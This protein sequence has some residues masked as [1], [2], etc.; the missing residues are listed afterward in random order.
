[1]AHIVTFWLCK[2]TPHSGFVPA[3]IYPAGG[4]GRN[5]SVNYHKNVSR[6]AAQSRRVGT[7]RG[8]A[9]MSKYSTAQDRSVSSVS[10]LLGRGKQ[11]GLGG[12]L[13]LGFMQEELVVLQRGKKM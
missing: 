11:P 5:F 3:M 2:H 12:Q 9:A 1:M 10:T 8:A 4:G 13:K 6:S 7:G